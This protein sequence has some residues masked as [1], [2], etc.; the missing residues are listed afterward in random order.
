MQRLLLFILILVLTHPVLAQKISGIVTDAQTGEPLPFVNVYYKDMRMG[1]Q[2]NEKGEYA[3]SYH[4]KEL[5]FSCVGY[6]TKRFTP[7]RAREFNVMLKQT[8]MELGTATILGQRKKYSRKNNPAVELMK[9]VIARK[10]LASLKTHDYYSFYRYN[11]LVLSVNNVNDSL[12]NTSFA[13]KNPFIFDHVETCNYTGKRILPVSVEES[14]EREVYRKST[15]TQKLHLLGKTSSGINDI[16]A[17]G[18]ILNTMLQECF[19]SV[20]INDDKV[21]LLQ[22]PF[23]SPLSTNYAIGFYRYFLQD[24]LM[25]EGQKCI[26]VAFTPNNPQDFGFS[27]HLY[28][29]ADSTHRVHRADITIPHRSDVNFVE[30]M[31]IIQHFDELPTGE[32]VLGENQ[33]ILELSLIEGTP[34]MQVKRISRFSGYSF[35]TL[36]DKD[37]DFKGD[38]YTDSNAQIRDDDF[39]QTYRPSE[40]TDSEENMQNFVQSM[41]KMKGYRASIWVIKA[42]VENFVETSTDPKRP[43]KVD[44]GPVNTIFS[45]NF[46]EGY[47][48][49]GSFQTTANL[50]PQLFFKGYAAYGIDDHC[51][52]GSAEF[53]YTFEPKQYMPHE[54]PGSKLSLTLY[55]DVVSPSDKFVS[56]DKDNV[57]TSF[58]WTDVYHML[59][60]RYARLQLYREWE[61]GLSYTLAAK[62]QRDVPTAELFY[63]RLGADPLPN[64]D[65]AGNVHALHA[66]EFSVGL[67][68]RPG[69]KWLNTKQ[70]RIATN[71]DAPKFSIQHNFGIKGVLGSE[72]NY[73]FTELEIYKRFWTPSWG[74]IDTYIKAGA[75][76]NRVPFPYLIVPPAN[77][78]Y[79]KD[80]N[81]FSL[82]TNMEFLN[83]RYVALF[84]SW[85]LNGKILNRLPLIRH[86]KL[87][88]YFG[89]SAMW[90][91]LT[92][93]NNPFLAQNQGDARLFYFPGEY[94]ASGN[95]RY[96]SSAMDHGKPYVE[97]YFGLYNIFKFF[98]VE[99][100]RRLTYLDN[101]ETDRWGIRARFLMTF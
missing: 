32:Q 59:Y 34:S 93:K 36:P 43:S 65:A 9:K 92:S 73:N 46:V 23:I 37:F 54:F 41:Q 17:T 100:V 45:Q 71:Q 56:T 69:V 78:S 12:R 24:T 50:H 75:Q 47:R 49:R 30:S 67:T 83:D 88:E 48:I 10:N 60:T 19:T 13:R 6:D 42:F 8:D 98:N 2:T 77:L 58:K 20:N 52:K 61:S 29:M 53:T 90:G 87:R 96:I 72:Y 4:P 18:D 51:W 66:S 14:V 70:R 22:Y 95:F 33:M 86:L 40:L 84:S 94:D 38:T 26:D 64:T 27:G 55:D 11:K 68:Y 16:F 74:R 63:Q 76:W 7:K 97:A 44:I 85:E 101:P 35:A 31:R 21:Q 62:I 25:V 3:I 15:D 39:W 57:F 1:V 79:I 82:L 80:D 91:S 81:T 5:F 28:V 89:F 99:Y